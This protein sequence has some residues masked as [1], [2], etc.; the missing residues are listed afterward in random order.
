MYLVINDCY[1][2]AVKIVAEN[3]AIGL[4]EFRERLLATST[5]ISLDRDGAQA[6]MV[7]Y[8]GGPMPLDRFLRIVKQDVSIWERFE[9]Y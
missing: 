4:G 6:D 5:D 7:W 3:P 2:P 1:R 9:T 8:T